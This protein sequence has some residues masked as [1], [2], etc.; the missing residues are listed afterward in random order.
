MFRGLRDLAK[1]GYL[2]KKQSNVKETL[3]LGLKLYLILWLLKAICFG[4]S[5]FLDYYNI[6]KIP[7]HVSFQ[8]LRTYHPLFQITLIAIVAPTLEELAYRLGL[9][10][11][12]RNLTV[13]IAGIFY[14]ALKNF[15]ELDRIYCLMLSLALG[16]IVYFSLNQSTVVKLSEFWKNNRPKVFYGLLLIFGLMHL[17]NFEITVELLIF[18]LIVI[19]PKLVAG[20]IYGYARL[21]SGIVL[22]ICLHS[23]NNGLPK[24][25]QML[26]G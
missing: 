13:T 6:F 18:S 4:I 25:I 5:Y 17:V 15:T 2:P 12:K 23:L 14:F 9:I 19:L 8:L 10:F 7:T 21:S 26:T 22:A 16:V 11:S 24:L 3:V 1:F 20:F